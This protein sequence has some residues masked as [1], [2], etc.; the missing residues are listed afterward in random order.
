M[1]EVGDASVRAN[2]GGGSG[3]IRPG[4]DELE[5]ILVDPEG[6]QVAVRFTGQDAA[7]L[8]ARDDEEPVGR[9]GLRPDPVVCDRKHI[10]FRPLV[11]ANQLV[12]PE[13]PVRARRV[14]VE[15]AT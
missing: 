1:G 15:R 8:G 9:L 4:T 5:R 7:Q 6:E 13:L 11:V 10:E 14:R 2:P 3:E 12:R